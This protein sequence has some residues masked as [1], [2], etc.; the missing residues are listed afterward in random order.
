MWSFRSS[1][2]F[3]LIYFQLIVYV[4][5]VIASRC[6]IN[7]LNTILFDINV[8]SF[9]HLKDRFFSLLAKFKEISLKVLPFFTGNYHQIFWPWFLCTNRTVAWENYFD[10]KS[11]LGLL[12]RKN[13]YVI[14]N[15]V[16]LD[17]VR[18]CENKSTDEV[19][20]RSGTKGIPDTWR[21]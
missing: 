8:K 20:R 16:A 11:S 7:C 17:I 9:R 5:V 18:F 21:S 12:V 10:L 14:S 15:I 19:R 4:I 2:L 3:P 6:V 1:Y 13:L